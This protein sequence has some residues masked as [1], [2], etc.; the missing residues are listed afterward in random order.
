ME[1]KQTVK[2]SVNP[3]HIKHGNIDEVNSIFDLRDPNVLN[4]LNKNPMIQSH[5]H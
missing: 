3:Y 1:L 4:L 2:A 5:L